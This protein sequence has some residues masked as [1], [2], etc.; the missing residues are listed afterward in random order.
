MLVVAAVVVVVLVP[1]ISNLT[2]VAVDGP[3]GS[4]AMGGGVT[5]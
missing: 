4:I 1:E 3:H 5:L 2:G